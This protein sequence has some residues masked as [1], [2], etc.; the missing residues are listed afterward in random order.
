MKIVSGALILVTV[1]LSVKHGW[2]GIT[3]TMSPEE[4]KM[5]NDLGINKPML[6]ALSVINLIIGLLILFPQTFFI[7]NVVNAVV[8]LLIMSMALKTGNMKT[9]LIE[10]PFLLMPLVLI[11]LGHPFKAGS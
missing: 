3:N 5:I 2:A 4:T 11:Y 10:I 8:I 1:F 6:L 9:A 7:A